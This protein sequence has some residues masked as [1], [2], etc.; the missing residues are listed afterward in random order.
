MTNSDDSYFLDTSTQIARHW[1]D[2]PIKEKVHADLH[3][4]K[5][6]CSI[7]V[8]R[9]YRC[10]VIDTF[11]K[12]HVFVKA[13]L[14]V[15]EAEERL[16]RAKDQIALDDLFYNV[17]KRLFRKY[18][19]KKPLLTR[20]ERLI[21]ADWEN[22]FY[23]SL[24][25]PLANFTDCT[26][27]ADAPKCDRGYYVN[28]PKSCPENCKI[29]EFWETKETDLRN[30][31]GMNITDPKGTM[32]KMRA[33]AAAIIQG[34][35]PHGDICND[36]SDAVISIGARDGYPGITIHTL[37]ADFDYLSPILNTRVRVFTPK[38][39]GKQDQLLFNNQ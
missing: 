18:N 35:D 2:D 31:A 21:E 4:K 19:S 33:Q 38:L 3:G 25:R 10:R 30:L 29:R 17:A 26:R 16:E 6:R 11:I 39:E 5:L 28:I 24:P 12:I 9:Q 32:P 7:Y 8:E 23:D 37:D 1:E 14:D 20:L 22:H 27:G 13:S 15:E 36:L 34:E